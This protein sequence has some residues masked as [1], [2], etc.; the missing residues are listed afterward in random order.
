[1]LT[2]VDETAVRQHAEAHGQAV[3]AGDLRTAGADLD[4]NA[5]AQAGDVMKQLPRTLTSS[6]IVS[7]QDE[8]DAAVVRTR[9][10]GDEGEAIVESRWQQRGDRPKIVSM[11]VGE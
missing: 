1:M 9:Y 2:R 5:L 11:T 10:A 7:L 4:G 3:V 6:E 8:G